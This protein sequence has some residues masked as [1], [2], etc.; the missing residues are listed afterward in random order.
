MQLNAVGAQQVFIRRQVPGG[1]AGGK[2]QQC[3]NGTD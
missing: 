3:Q 1:I 2:R